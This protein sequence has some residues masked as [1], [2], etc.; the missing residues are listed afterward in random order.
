MRKL[1]T[2]ASSLGLSLALSLAPACV[3][4]SLEL[5]WKAAGLSE[6]QAAAHLLERFA[7][8]PRPGEIDELV[9]HGLGN[10]FEGQ[11]AGDL[12]GALLEAKL[13]RL[14]AL[15][16]SHAE[17]V[18]RYG[19]ARGRILKAAL[20]RGVVTRED[21]TG[22]RGETRLRDALAALERFAAEQGMQ[23]DSELV[24][25]LRAQKLW[26]AVDSESQLVEVLTDFW[27]NHFNVSSSDSTARVHVLSFERDA[28][29]PRV[30]GSFRELLGAVAHHPAMLTYL[31]NSLSVA[32]A[33]ATTLFDLEVQDLARL[34]PLDDPTARLRLARDV[35]WTHRDER[36]RRPN[37]PIGLNE[38]YAR[39]LLELHTLG[40][41]GGYSQHDVVEVARALTGWGTFPG[42]GA[43]AKLEQALVGSKTAEDMGF[44]VDGE[45]VFRADHHDSDPKVVLG[46]PLAAGRGIE[47][48]EE[49]LDL[50]ARHPATARHLARKLA[51]RFVSERPPEALVERLVRAWELSDGDLTEVLLALVRSPELWSP[52]ARRRKVKTPFE[53]AAFSLRALGSDLREPKDTLGRIARMG[54][55]IYAY[56]APTGFPDRNDSWLHVGPLLARINFGRD[57]ARGRI[58]GVEL[59]LEEIVGRRYF[60]SLEEAVA[61]FFPRLMPERNPSWTV[62]LVGGEEKLAELLEAA[63]ADASASESPETPAARRQSLVWAMDAVGL[64]IGSPEFQVR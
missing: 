55:S 41:Q 21:Y 32:G 29:R 16:L 63:A 60:G 59:D 7:Y 39:E 10:W 6:R 52:E 50:L 14:P 38:N 61:F 8:G 34:S 23:P 62:A 54:Q 31:G 22:E 40:V 58:P 24:D 45:F 44:V 49:V 25:Q 26:R 46:L 13:A 35:G 3:A 42:G 1:S 15:S 57:L 33:G 19:Y 5:P 51:V 9:R 47:D 30:L 20:D 17:V 48:G 53:L 43:R 36:R 2:F 64:L 37:Q 18:E 4:S 12:P 56:P 11:L 27:F 28:I